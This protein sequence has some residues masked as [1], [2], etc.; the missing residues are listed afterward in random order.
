MSRRYGGLHVEQGDLDGRA[1][2][3]LVAT[4]AWLK[5][6]NYLPWPGHVNARRERSTG[7]N[8]MTTSTAGARV[9][10][11]LWPSLLAIALLSVALFVL[12]I[13]FDLRAGGSH[14]TMLAH[15]TTTLGGLR[16]MFGTWFL[17]G[18]LVL[19]VLLAVGAAVL[20]VNSYQLLRARLGG[21]AGACSVGTS[22]L[23]GFGT[24]SCP[25]CTVPLLGTLGVTFAASSMPLYGL[26]FKLLAL[27]LLGATLVWMRRRASGRSLVGPR[28]ATSPS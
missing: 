23:I 28:P 13:F 21:R 14:Q 22:M 18:T 25:S 4:Q 16:E 15:K 3:R 12:Y 17:V 8:D 5:A 9:E 1:L 19:D 27:V 26:E 24:F 10:R 2:G 20:M 6:T 7:G 11:R